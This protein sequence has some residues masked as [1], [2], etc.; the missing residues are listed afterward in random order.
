MAKIALVSHPESLHHIEHKVGGWYDTGLT[1]RGQRQ[2]KA[3]ATALAEAGIHACSIY[4][5]DLQRTAQ[6]A[7]II[8]QTLASPV[9]LDQRLREMSYGAAEGRDQAWFDQQIVYPPNGVGRLDHRIYPSSENRREV[10]TR[11]YAAMEMITATAEQQLVIVTH[12]FAATFVI[13][14]WLGMPLESVGLVAFRVTSGSISWLTQTAPFHNRM[15]DR[16]N[17]TQH[18]TNL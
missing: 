9:I 18:L 1:E 10:A 12:G 14:A 3:I 4:S 11:V 5:S 15:L 2:A 17:D 8:A 6:T 13:A 7:E 16:L